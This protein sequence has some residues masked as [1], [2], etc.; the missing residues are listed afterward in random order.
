LEVETMTQ[1]KEKLIMR[2][3]KTVGLA[4]SAVL[5]LAASLAAES[6]TSSSHTTYP[7]LKASSISSDT[8]ED[9]PDL[10]RTSSIGAGGTAEDLPDFDGIER[11]KPM[12][13]LLASS[14]IAGGTDED[15]PDLQ[16]KS[17]AGGVDENLPDLHA[18]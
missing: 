7:I 10:Q 1:L 11:D 14:L 9:V 16:A 2:S 3:R 5:S 8:G 4:V 17:I 18:S 6:A 12:P 13:Q 15:L